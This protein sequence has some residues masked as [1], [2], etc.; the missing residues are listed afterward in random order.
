MNGHIIRNERG[1]SFVYVIILAVLLAIL[2]SGFL[3]MSNFNMQATM[4]NRD[5]LQEEYLAKSIH[6][7]YCMQAADGELEILNKMLEDINKKAEAY[8]W[9]C[10]QAEEE[11]ADESA[12][13]GESVEPEYPPMPETAYHA[14]TASSEADGLSSIMQLK[15]GVEVYVKMELDFEVELVEYTGK[16]MDGEKHATLNTMVQVGTGAPYYFS[17]V[18]AYGGNMQTTSLLPVTRQPNANDGS[19][20]IGA[21]EVLAGEINLGESSR[22]ATKRKTLYKNVTVDGITSSGGYDLVYAGDITL[23]SLAEAQDIFAF[24]DITVGMGNVQGR[25]YSETGRVTIANHAQIKKGIVAGGDVLVGEGSGRSSVSGGIIANGDITIGDDS[26]VSGEI[27]TVGDGTAVIIHSSGAVTVDGSVTAP[28]VK[29]N[30]SV[31]ITGDIVADK[32]SIDTS[33]P[34]LIEGTIYADELKINGQLIMLATAG[35]PVPEVRV[36]KFNMTSGIFIVDGKVV[37]NDAYLNGDFNSTSY[38]VVYND[39][40]KGEGLLTVSGSNGKGYSL[41]IGGDFTSP[42][43]EVEPPGMSKGSIGTAVDG[44]DWTASEL[45]MRYPYA[46]TTY[47]ALIADDATSKIPKG[48]YR[49][50]DPTPEGIYSMTNPG[51]VS[52]HNMIEVQ[53]DTIIY[54]NQIDRLTGLQVNYSPWIST[55]AAPVIYI[56]LDQYSGGKTLDLTGFYVSGVPG[57]RVVFYSMEHVNIGLGNRVNATVYIPHGTVDISKN[58]WLDGVLYTERINMNS[59]SVLVVM[60]IKESQDEG[61]DEM[62]EG[63]GTIVYYPAK[64][65]DQFE[66][67]KTW[68]VKKHSQG[69]GEG[70][71]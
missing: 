56:K 53:G 16:V 46:G 71:A 25:I 31:R 3:Y 44:S 11:A 26:V 5:E 32:V 8:A 18:I 34:A 30:G 14:Y 66:T 23:N 20:S 50:D 15:E 64:E 13:S 22:Y 65:I 4:N 38:W 36:N 10:R 62:D 35:K 67:G 41:I 57:T 68:G 45:R 54:L 28:E 70:E 59:S 48:A 29:I 52:G 43:G 37:C 1:S 55:M 42:D 24:G 19:G 58:T 60:G 9:A 27:K 17:S 51:F 49:D 12:K 69:A 6:N 40:I 21:P 7:A 39:L 2:S 63:P 61:G 47:E 33:A